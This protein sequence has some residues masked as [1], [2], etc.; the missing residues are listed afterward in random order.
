ML[1]CDA[2]MTHHHSA[3]MRAVWLMHRAK[4]CL[5]AADALERKIARRKPRPYSDMEG[6]ELVRSVRLLR[7]MAREYDDE[8]AAL[9]TVCRG[10]GRGALLSDMQGHARCED[11]RKM[12]RR[13]DPIPKAL[14]A[15]LYERDGMRC[16]YCGCDVTP[17]VGGRYLPTDAVLDHVVP[18]KAGGSD[19]P[20]NLV[21]ACRRCN[22]SKCD[23]TDWVPRPLDAD[24]A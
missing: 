23:A 1:D 12:E 10:C 13:R 2:T 4:A 18:L 20:D 19:E 6:T 17:M 22:N 9:R 3:P 16:R 21:V 15:A 7:K 11:C 24:A 14:R 8:R 5:M